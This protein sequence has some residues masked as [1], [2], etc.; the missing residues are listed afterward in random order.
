[1]VVMLAK[2]AG[3]PGNS[4]PEL[5]WKWQAR[6]R[7]EKRRPNH[8]SG[9][10]SGSSHICSYY[11]F[12]ISIRHESRVKETNLFQKGRGMDNH[13]Q[14]AVY[15]PGDADISVCKVIRTYATAIPLH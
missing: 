2:G 6:P 3:K 13:C 11:D 15:S 4:S 14:L 9:V 1:M 10:P 5:A 12:T 7:I 8:M